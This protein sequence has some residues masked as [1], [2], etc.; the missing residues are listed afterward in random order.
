AAT[1]AVG[2][3][4]A[5]ASPESA[6]DAG[7]PGAGAVTLPANIVAP[8]VHANVRVKG[9]S[10][11]QGSTNWSGYV[12]TGGDFTTVTSTWQQPTVSCTSNGVVSFW[13]GLDGWGDQ[14]VEQTGTGADCRSGSPQYYAWWETF[15]TNSQQTYSVA[16]SPGD[17]MTA[18]VTFTDG[19][20]EL[21]LTDQS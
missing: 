7:T 10:A 4:A 20:Y 3:T 14:A 8:S 1:A 19:Q 21:D 6:R 16:V 18:T 12:A 9:A 13:V 2:I 17:T 11:N 15:P 5:Q